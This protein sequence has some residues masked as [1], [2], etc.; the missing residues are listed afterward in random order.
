MIVSPKGRHHFVM[1]NIPKHQARFKKV[2]HTIVLIFASVDK[3]LA[4]G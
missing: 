1:S 4:A 3:Q 2:I